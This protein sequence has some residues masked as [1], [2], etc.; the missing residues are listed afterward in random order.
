MNKPLRDEFQ[1]REV[2]PNPSDFMLSALLEDFLNQNGPPDLKPR[3]LA[4][5]EKIGTGK[6]VPIQ[7]NYACDEYD[8]AMQAASKEIESGYEKNVPPAPVEIAEAVDEDF[9]IWIRRGILLVAALAAVVIAAI[10]LPDSM[11]SRQGVLNQTKLATNGSAQNN[12][13]TEIP[14]M[15]VT[16]GAPDKSSNSPTDSLAVTPLENGRRPSHDPASM[17]RDTIASP[18]ILAVKQ[19][20]PLITKNNSVPGDVS[21]VI[22][23]EEVVGVIDSQLNYLWN[24]VGLTAAPK[25]QIDVWL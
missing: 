4:R 21:K 1:D 13:I 2:A 24:R 14:A 20:T 23:N 7:S 17:A 18:S 15:S 11:N 25:V 5:L 6:E 19:D 12:P 16:K 9:A 22:G 3:I 10:F 8:H